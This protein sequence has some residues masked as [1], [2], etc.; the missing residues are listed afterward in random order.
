MVFIALSLFVHLVWFI[1]Q[2]EYRVYIPEQAGSQFAV[3]LQQQ[4]PLP[5]DNAAHLP[6]KTT[7]TKHTEQKPD[8][9]VSAEQASS[10]DRISSAK[11]MTEI[12]QKLTQH[13]VYPIMAR[14]LGWQGQVLLGF[15]IDH[16]GSIQKV[17]IKQSSGYAILDDSAIT[18]LNKIGKIA[19][20]AGGMLNGIWQLEI[21]IIYRLEG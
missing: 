6:D 16:G 7:K 17:H 13:F 20:Q 5:Q 9:Q 2:Q 8:K 11:V 12:R 10:E 19:V 4:K 15:Q 3:R 1:G 18:A 14:R 21:P